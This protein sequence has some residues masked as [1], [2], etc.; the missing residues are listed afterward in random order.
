MVFSGKNESVASCR[1]VV[2]NGTEVAKIGHNKENK[3]IK[4]LTVREYSDLM[5]VSESTIKSRIREK[6][7]EAIQENGKY[8]IIVKD[9]KR[10]ISKEEKVAKAEI[11]LLKKEIKMLKEANQRQAE[12]LE[13]L[14]EL[15]TENQRLHNKLHDKNDR[16]E[17]KFEDI[18]GEMKNISQIA[19]KMKEN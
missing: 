12:E 3:M 5:G 6:K 14:Q 10:I 8:L 15:R 11:R 4:K 18:Y 1:Q 13:E 2:A 19:L 9:A 17:L 16:Y 7:L